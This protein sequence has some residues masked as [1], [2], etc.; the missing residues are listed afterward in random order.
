MVYFTDVS[1]F[2]F[3]TGILSLLAKLTKRCVLRITRDHFYFIIQSENWSVTQHLLVWAYI[4]QN[5]FFD[6]YNL[7]GVSMHTTDTGEVLKDEIMLEI[8]PGK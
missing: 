7:T 2:C 4:E 8:V 6:V 3:V 1:P 5:K